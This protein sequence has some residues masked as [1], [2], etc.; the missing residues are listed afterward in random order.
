MTKPQDKE[1]PRNEAEQTDKVSK[2]GRENGLFK[3]C[4]DKIKNSHTTGQALRN[5]AVA[6]G[7][8]SDRENYAELLSL[9]YVATRAMEMRMDEIHESNSESIDSLTEKKFALLK[10]VKSLGYSFCKGYEL[11][12]EHLLGQ[13]W[14]FKVDEMTTEPAKKYVER[15]KVANENELV[16][17]AF[18]LWGPLVIG[19]EPLFFSS[20][21]DNFLVRFFINK[22]VSFILIP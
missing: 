2:L 7:A 1:E 18:I 8:L 17:A 6:A 11:D 22:F 3:Q 9:F 10:E 15:L 20:F 4:M 5:A 16:A 13:N 12:L 14:K 19:G 21:N